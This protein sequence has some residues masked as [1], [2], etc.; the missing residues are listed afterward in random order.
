[1]IQFISEQNTNCV[2]LLLGNFAKEKES[3]ILNKERIIKGAHPSPLSA[4]R[5][6][7]F[8]SGVFIKVEELLNKQIDW[9]N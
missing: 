7:F 2:F 5:C 9:N 3:D 8:H 1:M 4:L 6:G